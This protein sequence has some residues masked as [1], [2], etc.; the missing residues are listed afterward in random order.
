MAAVP[1][2][3]WYGVLAEAMA[4]F[5]LEQLAIKWDR[6]R[7]SKISPNYSVAVFSYAKDIYNRRSAENAALAT[8]WCDCPSH[9]KCPREWEHWVLD[10]L[11][12]FSST[13]LFFQEGAKLLDFCVFVRDGDSKRYALCEFNSN[14]SELLDVGRVKEKLLSLEYIRNE[15]AV[16]ER[17]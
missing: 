1:R 17:K 8:I 16:W 12:G 6:C 10:H 11:H 15:M 13:V 2:S 9:K 4:L 7:L 5:M 14:N 3:K